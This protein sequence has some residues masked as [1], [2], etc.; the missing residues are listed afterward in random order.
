MREN[1]AKFQQNVA[2]SLR[3][4]SI[5]I[6]VVDASGASRQ[7]TVAF[8]NLMDGSAGGAAGGGGGGR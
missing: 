1:P 8:P 7:E 2:A 3:G 6:D 5:R 4:G